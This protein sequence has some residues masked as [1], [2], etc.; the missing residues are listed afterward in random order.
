ML[1]YSVSACFIINLT[2]SLNCVP[3]NQEAVLVPELRFSNLSDGLA[4]QHCV[5]SDKRWTGE[6]WAGGGGWWV[7]VVTY[8]SKRASVTL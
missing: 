4:G 6:E 2:K 3:G 8:R 7:G 1:Q 5:W